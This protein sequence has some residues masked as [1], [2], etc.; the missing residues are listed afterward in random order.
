MRK[1][2]DILIVPASEA[3]C[4]ARHFKHFFRAIWQP[5]HIAWGWEI[6]KGLADL[7]VQILGDIRRRSF[8]VRA[9]SELKPFLI[10]TF[11]F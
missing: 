1:V 6:T 2:T 7:V 10:E 4:P 5:A 9:V 3:H 8:H 11:S